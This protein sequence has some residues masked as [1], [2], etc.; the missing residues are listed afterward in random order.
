MTRATAAASS[1]RR[2]STSTILGI[3]AEYHSCYKLVHIVRERHITQPTRGDRQMVHVPTRG[4]VPVRLGPRR[5]AR[6]GPRSEHDEPRRV[7][8]SAPLRAGARAGAGQELDPRRPVGAGG[9]ARR[10]AHVRGSRRDGGRHPPA[11]RF[12]RRVPQRVPAPRS[13]HRR[14]V[15]RLR[16]PAIHVPVPRLGVRHEGRRGRRA[17]ARGLRPRAPRGRARP[18]GRRRRL[19]RLGVD[20]HGRS[21]RRRR[22]SWRPSA[23]RSRPTSGAS[24]W[25]T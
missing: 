19:G 9:R 14:S 13:R 18:C 6:P 5:P 24:T 1:V 17:R 16:R 7:H 25:R 4:D 8:R 23:R 3:D 11:R 10:L 20:Q 2:C 12:G 21:R 15:H 22:R